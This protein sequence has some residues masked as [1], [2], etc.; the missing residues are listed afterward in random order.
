MK[1]LHMR[2]DA[3]L[4]AP[5]D[6]AAIALRR[7]EAGERIQLCSSEV[8]LP[9]TI[10]EGHRV[11]TRRIHSGDPILSWGLPFG[12]ARSEILPGDYLCNEKIL[13]TLAQ[14]QVGFTLPVVPNFDD[15]W[16][17]FRFDPSAFQPG[18][19]VGRSEIPRTFQGFLR[20]RARGA[21]TRNYVV[22]L[23]T[24]ART[25]SHARI[26]A[27]HFSNIRRE[28]SNIDGVVA[29]AHTEAAGPHRPNN[30]EITLRTLEGFLTNSNVAAF[31]SLDLGDEPLT[32]FNLIKS[33]TQGNN[34]LD[35]IPH[36]FL[37]L[38]A[39]S[40]QGID[41]ALQAVT[42]LLPLANA[43]QRSSVPIQ[44]LK[45]GLQCGGSDAFNG[46]SANPLIGWIAKETLRHGGI[47]NLCE[48]DELIGA[49]PDIL[50]NVRDLSTVEAFLRHRDQFQLWARRHGHSA[51][52][53]PSGGNLF[54]GLYNISIKSIGA[55]RKRDPS[56]RLDQVIDFAEP[57][58][59]PGFYFMNSPGNDL[60]SISGQVASGCNL[61]LFATG[62]GS[63]T[64][65]P[66]VPTLKVMSTTN[67]FR[68][69]SNEMDF[70]A[71]RYLDGESLPDLGAEAFNL[72]IDLASGRES[73]GEKAGHSQVQLWRD[74]HR[75]ISDSTLIADELEPFVSQGIS[76]PLE[77]AAEVRHSCHWGVN[78][79][80]PTSLC[81]SQIAQL[82]VERFNKSPSPHRFV[83]LPHTEGCGVSGGECER[84][85]LSTMTGYL[86]HPGVRRALLLEHGC[87]KTHLDAF[88]DFMT[89]RGLDL[90]Q[91]GTASIQQDGGLDRVTE[92]VRLWFER[93]SDHSSSPLAHQ[94]ETL[95]RVGILIQSEF[96]KQQGPRVG[97]FISKLLANGVV[98]CPKG[99]PFIEPKS[100][101]ILDYGQPFSDRGL[102]F[103]HC[104]TT[105]PIEILS[106][107][108]ATGV[109]VLLMFSNTQVWPAHPFI[110]TLQF[111]ST[112]GKGV[113]ADFSNTDE[114]WM[115]M[116]MEAARGQRISTMQ[117]LKHVGFQIT[118]GHT[119]VS[120]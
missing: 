103:M 38:N 98:V 14:R 30:F 97:E 100:S 77:A 17:P 13:L 50:S 68:L 23:G 11:A 2:N 62:N 119:G 72:A 81:S 9:F 36:H 101:I 108:G 94:P 35:S 29:I 118:R 85:L 28:F 53:N 3:L 1:P 46:I 75:P 60:E 57:M 99:T 40:S 115:A 88:R 4:P 69:L 65:F 105:Q 102:H 90:S 79:I 73:V 31:V 74:W 43:C 24:T 92:K 26:V 66:F 63:I 93:A 16:E 34:Y 5:Y 109:D 44:H 42:S 19:Q 82:I 107:L 114:E 25:A 84:L 58:T 64:N 55:A 49:E 45:I 111:C 104:P 117:S 59:E 12:L 33:L 15:H 51:E 47:A 37:T 21:G 39:D 112:S 96:E 70:N 83:A 71:G 22:V 113:D 116:I 7:L 106:G 6:N 87:E 80:V 10:L 54:R 91:L 18:R 8:I 95:L 48:T 120:L 110:P 41:R 67:R 89:K 78:L 76:F 32:N 52:G 20:P 27:Q 61:I 56:V 86:V